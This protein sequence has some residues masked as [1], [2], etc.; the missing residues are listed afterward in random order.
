MSKINLK[1]KVIVIF[2]PT[3]SGKTDLAVRISKFIWGTYNIESAII[4][5]D[6]RQVY[7]GMD[8]GTNKTPPT[9]TSRFPHHMINLTTPEAQYTTKQYKQKASKILEDSLKN[10]ELPIIVG[11]TGTYIMSLVGDDILKYTKSKTKRLYNVLTLIPHFHRPSLYKR[12]ERNVDDMFKKGLY[13]EVVQLF[14]KYGPT[15]P[16]QKTLGYGDFFEYC[17]RNNKEIDTLSAKDLRKISQKIQTNTKTYAMHQMG[18]L[19][20]IDRWSWVKDFQKTKKQIKE[21]LES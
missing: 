14:N 13:E 4:S 9:T 6:S 16:L 15:D 18:W 21:F 7:L 5:A 2:G 17:R 1:N 8:I 19:K 12:I 3:S 10:N 20:K 11:G